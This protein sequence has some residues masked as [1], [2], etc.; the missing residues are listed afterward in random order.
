MKTIIENRNMSDPL[1]YQLVAPIK[2]ELKTR[3]NWDLL[4]R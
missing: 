1:V 3:N 4:D 2:S